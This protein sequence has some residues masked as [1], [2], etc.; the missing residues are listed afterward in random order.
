MITKCE[1]KDFADIYDII[2]DAAIAYKGIIPEDRWHEPY[3]TVDELK[4]QIADNVEFWGY[5]EDN[6][7]MGVMGIQCKGDVTLIR[8]AYV[9]TSDRNKGIGGKLLRHLNSISSTP[10]LIG[11]WA[12]AKWAIDF[13]QKHGF[14]LL[15]KD[16][17]NILLQKYWTIPVRQIE[18]SVVLA[19]SNWES[20]N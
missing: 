20:K 5:K 14:R 7:I 6:K 15:L 11:T 3:M 8:H 4:K 19:G 1:Q 10:V 12:D 2:N 13:Y 18:T 17:V 16:E 9:R